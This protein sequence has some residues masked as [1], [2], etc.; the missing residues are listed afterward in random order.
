MKDLLSLVTTAVVIGEE[1]GKPRKSTVLE[2]LPK[3]GKIVFKADCTI[4][5][6]LGHDLKGSLT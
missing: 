5:S 6:R 1:V 4:G 2:R 3:R